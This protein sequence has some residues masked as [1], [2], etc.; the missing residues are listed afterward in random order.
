MKGLYDSFK[1]QAGRSKWI[2]LEFKMAVQI[3]LKKVWFVILCSELALHQVSNSQ[4]F[5]MKFKFM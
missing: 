5:Y 1:Y 3:K 4:T 2:D